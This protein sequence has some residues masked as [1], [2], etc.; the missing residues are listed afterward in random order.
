VRG[1]AEELPRLTGKA[2]VTKVTDCFFVDLPQAGERK[3]I[4]KIQI[5]KHGR[6]PDDFDIQGLAQATEGYTG[7]EIEQVFINALYVAYSDG[8]RE[9]TLADIIQSVHDVHPL[10]K[11]MGKEIQALRNWCKDRTRSASTK[12]AKSQAVNGQ[13][14]RRIQT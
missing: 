4:W 5:K 14:K 10:S 3:D 11:L 12:Q 1:Y 6:N 8:A 7:A 2:E 13:G 9:P